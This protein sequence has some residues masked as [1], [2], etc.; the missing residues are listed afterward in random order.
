MDLLG[1][2]IGPKNHQKPMVFLYFLLTSTFLP[3][4]S[5][6]G[7]SY[8]YL[9]RLEAVLG[10]P[11]DH[12]GP[13]GGDLGAIL[14][15]LGAI[16]GSSSGPDGPSLA[17]LGSSWATLW[18]SSGLSA[19]SWIIL[20][21]SLAVL[22]PSWDRFG[23]NPVPCWAAAWSFTSPLLGMECGRCYPAGVSIRP[24]SLREL[25]SPC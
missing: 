1:A 16:L 17:V 24:H 9:A 25:Q 8:D 22:G 13:A 6:L 4:S 18:P 10:P 23:K 3:I 2:H 20:R 19:S 14:G 5:I 12:L 7:H 15:H 21:S 11:W